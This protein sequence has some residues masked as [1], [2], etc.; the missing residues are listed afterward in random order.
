[1]RS[2]VKGAA[3]GERLHAMLGQ[4]PNV[5][6][7]RGKG[8]FWGIEIVKDRETL[9]P[10]SAEANVTMGVVVNGLMQGTFIY[11]GGTGPVRDIVCLGPAFT[12][13]DDE[14]DR[15]VEALKSSIDQAVQAAG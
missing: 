13:E 4:H 9:E 6:E 14:L 12:V 2:A 1:E 15:M 3:L 8:L 5:A 11:G 10:F 7:I